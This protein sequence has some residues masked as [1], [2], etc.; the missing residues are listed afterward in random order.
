MAENQPPANQNAASKQAANQNGAPQYNASY[1]E[2]WQYYMVD[3]AV[4]RH[5]WHNYHQVAEG[6]WR[7][8]H[9]TVKRLEKMSL[10]GIRTIISLRGVPNAPHFK[11]ESAACAAYGMSF[12]STA[13]QARK[14]PTP[15]ALLHLLDLFDSVERP[16]VMHC[17]SGADRAGLASALYLLHVEN[18]PLAEAQAQ[19]SFK[20]LHIKRS[21][22]GVL[23]LFLETY[24]ASG[25]ISIRDWIAT[26]YD[27]DALQA[28]FEAGT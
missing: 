5:K 11:I 27:R 17:K 7:S 23:D 1:A 8:N 13:L 18:R 26:V 14:A 28:A 10:N 25:S 4:L 19:L 6:A 24:G 21:K 16:F 20:Y 3:H 9:P 22:T 12:V 2:L 15:E